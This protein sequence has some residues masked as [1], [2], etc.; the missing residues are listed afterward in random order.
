[1]LPSDSTYASVDHFPK[2]EAKDKIKKW[3]GLTVSP[4]FPTSLFHEYFSKYLPNLPRRPDLLHRFWAFFASFL[5]PSWNIFS[6]SPCLSGTWDLGTWE[7]SE[8]ENNS[9]FPEGKWA[10]L[11]GGLLTR[12]S[13]SPS[14]EG[15]LPLLGIS[16][17]LHHLCPFSGPGFVLLIWEALTLPLSL[18]MSCCNK[19]SSFT[20]VGCPVAQTVKN[21]PEMQE[22]GVQSPGREDPLEKEMAAH[23]SILAWG[24]QW[25]EEPL[26][27]DSNWGNEKGDPSLPH[28]LPHTHLIIL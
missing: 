10:W 18:L 3:D 1:M 27:L 24:I 6:C 9:V 28:L 14:R 16:L 4:H 13:P 23:S 15:P 5:Q 19:S 21:M 26:K 2:L 22:T 20:L 12:D 25:T 8:N 11:W 7:H 17:S